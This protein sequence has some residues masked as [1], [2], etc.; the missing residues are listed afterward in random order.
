MTRRI[1]L[2]SIA[3]YI[4]HR[5]RSLQWMVS[6]FV[7]K[8]YE[9]ASGL[10][11]SSWIRVSASLEGAGGADLLTDYC[12]RCQSPKARNTVL[13][14]WPRLTSCSYRAKIILML[15]QGHRRLEVSLHLRKTETKRSYPPRSIWMKSGSIIGNWQMGRWSS[16]KR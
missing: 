16:H 9:T 2:F 11:K 13:I 14:Q 10:R 8:R 5:Y 4:Q 7:T 1:L 15:N 6:S 12:R 3:K